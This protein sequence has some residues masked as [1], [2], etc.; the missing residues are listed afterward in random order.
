MARLPQV[1]GDDGNWGTILNE[2]LHQAHNPNGTLKSDSVGVS[3][4]NSG[5]LDIAVKNI[6]EDPTSATSAAIVTAVPAAPAI[7]AS[8]PQCVVVATGNEARPTGSD[9]VFWIGGST[10][11]ANMG[12]NDIWYN[13]DATPTGDTT[14]PSTPT[15]LS[16]AAVTSSGFQ[17]SWNASTD[18]TGVTGY[19]VRID[20][21]TVA[22]PTTTSYS[23]SGLAAATTYTV[24]VRARDA[25]G[26][27]SPWSADLSVTTG[28]GSMTSH[29]VF[30]A[31]GAPSSAEVGPLNFYTD[32]A[33][34]LVVVNAFYSHA[35]NWTV[36]GARVWVPSGADTTGTLNL[37]AWKTLSTE[38]PDSNLGWDSPT[39]AKTVSSVTVGAWNEVVF[40]TPFTVNGIDSGSPQTVW[41]GYN[42]NGRYI[43]SAGVD[44][45]NTQA[46]DGADLYLSENPIPGTAIARAANRAGGAIGHV[47]Y[48]VDIVAG[49]S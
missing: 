6:V 48:G 15:G 10:Q 25:V 3:Q 23:A 14:V 49:L 13:S 5:E 33:P 44:D 43:H 32:G 24:N 21:S 31:S 35:A 26:N 36:T 45:T 47:Y 37:R 40:D 12:T 7:A 18:D 1:G 27:W 19:Q 42:W 2:F 30:A 29:T 20:G 22:S 4:L 41:I 39:Q 38:Y 34:E 16:V 8:Y 17:L 28:A 9:V 46:L 11:P